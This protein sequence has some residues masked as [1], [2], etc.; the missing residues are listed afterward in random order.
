MN[1]EIKSRHAELVSASIV[2]FGQVSKIEAASAVRPSKASA[3]TN[4]WMLKQVQNDGV[5]EVVG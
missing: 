5:Y 4:G 3:Q 1:S 2:Q